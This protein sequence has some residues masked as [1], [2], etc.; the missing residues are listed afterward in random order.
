MAQKVVTIQRHIQENQKLHPGS[1]GAF[2]NL[3]TQ[4]ALAAKLVS[5]QVNKAGLVD[6][7]GETGKINV[8]GE[9]V[10]KLDDYAQDTFYKALDHCGVLC[11]M[12]SEEVEDVIP[13]PEQFPRGNYLLCLDPLDGSSNIDC[14]VSIGTIF[15][16]YRIAETTDKNAVMA[17]DFFIKGSKQ[18]AA[19]YVIYGSSTMLVYTAGTG[20]HGFTLDPS[21]GEFLLSHENIR[22][23]ERGV[24]YSVNEGNY[25]HWSDTVRS[26][27][28]YF[29]SEDTATK[30]PRS[31]RYIGSLVADFHRNL[32]Q[33][34]VF[35]Y[36]PDRKTKTRGKLRLLFEANPLA[37]IVEQAGGAAIDGRERILDLIPSDLHERVPLFIGSKADVD[38]IQSLMQKGL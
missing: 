33:G 35:M 37:F 10:Q 13:I 7:V 6:I 17:K 14:N 30:R 1:S 9:M 31:A 3:L 5:Y 4:I 11:A 34:G 18:V 22:I 2:S 32:L 24:Y 28:E 21:V 15:S 36:P 29:K 20:A 12:A 38:M 25:A 27:V 19:G 23:P 8:Q 16:I 26:C